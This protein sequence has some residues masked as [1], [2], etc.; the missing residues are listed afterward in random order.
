[1]EIS[2]IFAKRHLDCDFFFVDGGITFGTV[3]K[4]M[5][6]N[7]EDGDILLD[8]YA[9]TD[10]YDPS[11]EDSY[12]I[13]EDVLE[14]HHTLVRFHLTPEGEQAR[15]TRESLP[16]SQ[17]CDTELPIVE[18][19]EIFWRKLHK[20]TWVQDEEALILQ[21]L[22]YF[23][24]LFIENTV[25]ANGLTVCFTLSVSTMI[26]QDEKIKKQTFQA[27][28]A[29]CHE[30]LSDTSHPPVTNLMETSPND[31]F[32]ETG[33][34]DQRLR[35]GCFLR[36]DGSLVLAFLH[37]PQKAHEWTTNM[38]LAP[39]SMADIRAKASTLPFP[40]VEV[41]WEPNIFYSKAMTYLSGFHI[42]VLHDKVQK[43]I[44]MYQKGDMGWNAD[45]KNQPAIGVY[46]SIRAKDEDW[47]DIVI[48]REGEDI[49]VGFAYEMD[50]EGMKI[51]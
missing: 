9:L 12:E 19:I 15:K 44:H 51:Y 7:R 27:L 14:N 5:R 46:P 40:F 38:D 18:N 48:K 34:H 22:K 42:N 4:S 10:L 29:F 20:E 3:I 32:E 28:K 39:V 33:R 26:E 43:S 41:E 1:M 23:P 24:P 35:V 13:T 2:Q 50:I 16:F 47:Q 36:E 8:A 45:P 49:F 37:E 17:M 30:R 21:K 6:D 25:D 31:G 11:A